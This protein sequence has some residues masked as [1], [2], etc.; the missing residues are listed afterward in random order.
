MS[1]VGHSLMGLSIGALCLPRAI[2]PVRAVATAAAL[3]V[4]AETPD[5]RLTGWGHHRYRVSHSVFVTCG[6]TGLYCNPP[7][8]AQ[9][10]AG[11]L[12]GKPSPRCACAPYCENSPL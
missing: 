9:H 12:N 2:R 1:F 3:S 4:L 6:H 8:R 5:I 11:T 10:R 7:A